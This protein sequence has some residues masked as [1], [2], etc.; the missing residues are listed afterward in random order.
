[1]DAEI[2]IGDFEGSEN[3]MSYEEGV[4]LV[5]AILCRQESR[6]WGVAPGTTLE[7]PWECAE[8]ELFHFYATYLDFPRHQTYDF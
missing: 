3:D 4:M 6:R 1:L 8:M 2:T 5:G 7:P